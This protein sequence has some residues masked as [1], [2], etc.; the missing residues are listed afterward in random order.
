[1]EIDYTICHDFSIIDLTIDAQS[2]RWRR[3]ENEKNYGLFVMCMYA[4]PYR[5]SEI[6]DRAGEDG[7]G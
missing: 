5:L 3:Y 2:A 7:N 4:C 6:R 1:M